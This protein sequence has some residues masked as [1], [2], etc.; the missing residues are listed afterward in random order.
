MQPF[1]VISS[2]LL[3]R[4]PA[5]RFAFST[6]TGGVSPEPLGMNLSFRVG[7][8]KRNVEENRRLFFSHLGFAPEEVAFP[9]QCHSNRAVVVSGAGS[10]EACDAL[11]TK[12]RRV[13]LAV[14]VADCLPV[15]L[16]DPNNHAIAAIHAGWRGTA[17]S[18]TSEAI[19]SMM[20]E[21]GSDPSGLVAYL[22][23]GAD[24]CCYEIGKEVADLF[25][26]DLVEQRGGKQ[27]LNLKKANVRQLTI[28]GLK[29]DNIEVFRSCTICQPDLFHSFRREKERSGRM[30]GVIV[31][32]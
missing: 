1:P 17:A 16:F 31:L 18:I 11:L 13:P 10:Y 5:V 7:D 15:F 9:M 23:P 20:G 29:E 24:V 25:D 21:W 8:E 6:R 14:S 26:A 28:S 27:F 3:A 32:A 12:T 30:M 4:S 19:K 2:Q 22:G